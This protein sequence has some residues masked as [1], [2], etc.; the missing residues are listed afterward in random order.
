VLASVEP[1]LAVDVLDSVSK[2][3]LPSISRAKD[4]NELHGSKVGATQVDAAPQGRRAL[5]LALRWMC[6]MVAQKRLS[7]AFVVPTQATISAVQRTVHRKL[8][9]T[10][11]T[12][13]CLAPVVRVAHQHRVEDLW[14]EDGKAA[15]DDGH[16]HDRL[17]CAHR[18]RHVTA[19]LIQLL[20]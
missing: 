3:A 7:F 9:P 4:G 18:V 20:S 12:R 19:P 15:E 17:A 14:P 2:K 8:P 13:R 6:W 5:N 1:C 11:L 16:N 10:L